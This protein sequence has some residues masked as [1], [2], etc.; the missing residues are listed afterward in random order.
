MKTIVITGSTDGIGKLAATKLAKDGHQIIVHGRSEEKLQKTLAEIKEIS[1]N[2]SVDG[3]ISDLSDF[4]SIQKMI[5]ELKKKT[6]KIDVLINNAGVLKSSIPSN[7]DGLDLRF[8]VNYFA[9]YL[10]TQGLIPLLKKSSSPRLINLSSAAQAP[11]SLEALEGNIALS[12]QEAYAQ[13]KLALTMWSF[14]LSQKLD[15]LN[16]IAVNPGSLLNTRMVQEA[17]GQFWSSADKGATILYDLA[18]SE[19]YND[20]TGQYFDNDKGTFSKAHT[21]AYQQEKLERLIAET[22]KILKV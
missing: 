7:N 4:G 16:V 19:A 11:V 21:D 22:K 10:L 13:S 3:V 18:S 8:A 20:S 5:A 9:P 17:Y 6:P 14:Y 12:E 1:G 15:F 2:T